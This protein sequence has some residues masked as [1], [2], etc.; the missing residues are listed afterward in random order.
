[1]RK[2]ARFTMSLFHIF[3]IRKQISVSALLVPYH[4]PEKK[5]ILISKLDTALTVYLLSFLMAC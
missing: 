2:M 4:Y 1:M 3:S 5:D